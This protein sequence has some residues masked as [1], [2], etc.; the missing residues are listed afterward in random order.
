MSTN[1][2]REKHPVIPHLSRPRTTATDLWPWLRRE[3]QPPPQRKQQGGR[4]L[5]D[6]ERAHVS[7]L[8]GTGVAQPTARK[9]SVLTGSYKT[10]P[11]AAPIT[12]PERS[13]VRLMLAAHCL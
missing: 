1:H 12:K 13:R 11:S 4:L 5:S 9:P 3:M 10:I 2:M 8:G 7:P 6:A